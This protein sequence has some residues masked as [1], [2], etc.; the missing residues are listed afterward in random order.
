MRFLHLIGR[1]NVSTL[2]TFP[3]QEHDAIFH[4]VVQSIKYSRKFHNAFINCEDNLEIGLQNF[5]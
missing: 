3:L 5:V 1:Q 4:F 2:G